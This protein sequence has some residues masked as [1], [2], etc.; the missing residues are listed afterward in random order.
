MF[1]AKAKGLY[2]DANLEVDLRSPHIDEYKKTPASLVEQGEALLAVTPSESVIS[3]HLRPSA[4]PKPCLK[5]VAALL[6]EDDSAIVTKASSG[7][8]R[9]SKLDGKKYASYAARFEGRIVQKM[10]QNDGGKGDYQEIADPMLDLWQEVLDGKADATWVFM[11]WEGSVARSKGI[12]L[13]VFKL[14]DYAIP[15]GYSPVLVAHPD[16]LSSP[17]QSDAIRRFLTATADGYKYAASHPEAAAKMMYDI[18]SEEY[19]DFAPNIDP[20]VL[21][22]SVATVATLAVSNNV[23]G[24]M[25]LQRWNT[26]L[27]WLSDAGLLTQHVQSRTIDGDT[28]VSLDDLRQG[29]AGALIPRSDID[30]RNLFTNDFL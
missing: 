7:I 8:D 12:E 5:A 13:N 20:T 3:Y 14:G 6:Q 27:D 23:W 17:N 16:A 21:K 11:N 30:A 2:T 1:V 25:E 4:A 18:V 10:I 19:P 9:P 15:Y 22:D 28:F 26:F 24:K 29:N